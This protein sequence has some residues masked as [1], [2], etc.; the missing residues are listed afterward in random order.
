M[1]VIDRKTQVYHA[2]E[3]VVTEIKFT[4]QAPGAVTLNKHIWD[5]QNFNLNWIE[6]FSHFQNCRIGRYVLC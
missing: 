5:F 6:H 2:M 1:G 4:V 3:I